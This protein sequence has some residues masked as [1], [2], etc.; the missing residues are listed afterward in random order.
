MAGGS[1]GFF[2]APPTG[3][4]GAPVLLF[5]LVFFVAGHALMDFALQ[6][7]AMANCKCRKANHPLQ[8]AVPWYYWLSA[9][10]I[11]HG[12]M[13]GAIVHWA[14][15]DPPTAAAYALLEALIH[16]LIDVA[17]CEGRT[18]IHQDQALHIL[19]KIA[20]ALM[21]VNGIVLPPPG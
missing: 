15:F 10:A 16:W 6:G 11:L 8:K 3:P 21:L 4:P 1:A 19:C 12:A 2:P 13:V 17:K 18:N 14:K 5:L 9:H 7:D 20:W